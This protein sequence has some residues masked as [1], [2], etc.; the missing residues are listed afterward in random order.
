MASESQLVVLVDDDI[1]VTEALAVGLEREGRTV[2]TC[3]DL[4]SAELIIDRMHPSH[5]V[6][7]VRLSGPFGFE[8]LDLVR[9]V[10]RDAPSTRI[11]LISGNGAEDLQ[12]EASQRGA[13]A[14]LQKPFRVEELDATLDLISCTATS[15]AAANVPV[16]RVPLLEEVLISDQ[17]RPLFQPIVTLG[18]ERTI[19]GFES[20]ARFRMD[21]P[22]RN[23]DLLFLYA[24][25]KHRTADL[26]FACIGKTMEQARLLPADTSIFL[27]VHPE[28]L[29]T[30]ALFRKTLV[31]RAKAMGIALSRVVL[32]ITEQGTLARAPAA[33]ETID[34]LRSLGVRFAFDDLGVAYSHLPLIGDVRPSFLKISQEFGTAFEKDST[35]TK[36]VMNLLSLAQD[37]DCD[38]IVEG[39]E[40]ES[41]ARAARDLGIPFGQGFL[42]ARPADASTFAG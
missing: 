35:R 11:I 7:D 13:V 17:L 28:A 36:I 4:E 27:N 32:E 39:I 6:A 26:E 16:I 22:L 5:V 20:L 14:F 34:E 41:T 30:A 21:T 42:F 9:H 40:H 15:A 38:L 37:F 12:L 31:A 10:K 3:N 24:A 29:A 2:V 18:G 25:R 19:A 1:E 8:G 33:L 23:P